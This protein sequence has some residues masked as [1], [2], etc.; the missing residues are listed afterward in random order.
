MRLDA[1]GLLCSH[2]LPRPSLLRPSS[3]LTAFLPDFSPLRSPHISFSH[4]TSFLYPQI[5]SFF[6]SCVPFL[7]LNIELG[8]KNEIKKRW[9]LTLYH[10]QPGGTSKAGWGTVPRVNLT[11]YWV[12][13]ICQPLPW[14]IFFKVLCK[15]SHIQAGSYNRN[16]RQLQF[17]SIFQLL[18]GKKR[19][20]PK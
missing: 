3:S 14:K 6:K 15:Q 8:K 5:S 11:S 19:F 7:S 4:L 18:K 13:F 10:V 2:S 17:C 20:M 12:A 1:L 9:R 16:N